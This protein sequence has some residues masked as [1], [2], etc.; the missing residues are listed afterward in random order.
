MDQQGSE[1]VPNIVMRL[2]TVAAT[3]GCVALLALIFFGRDL[4]R[5][6]FDLAR[7]QTFKIIFLSI[8]LEALPFLLVGVLVS[9]LLQAFVSDK[10]IQK[11]TPRNPFAGVLFGSLLGIVL[12]LCE[13]GMIP[14]VRRLI[15]KGLPAYIGIIYIVAGP[16]INPIVFGATFAAFRTNRELAYSRFYLAFLVSVALGLILYKFM[17]RN[18][19][20]SGPEMHG[21]HGHD[22]HNHNP[23]GGVLKRLS[24]IPAHSA[25]EFF[26]MGK[27]LIL[28]SFI[29]A[30]L[31]T[32]VARASFAAVADHELLSHLFM[33]GFAYALSLCSTS[34]AFVAASFNNMFPPAAL[35]SFLV[36]GPML[37]LKNTLMMLAVFRKRFVLKFS[38]LIALLVLF[39][40]ILFDHLGLV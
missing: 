8:I 24:D 26:D 14:I 4:S 6:T 22:H 28:G 36:F 29:T 19:L 39:G 5:W 17:K 1:T 3:L 34:D 18:P 31:Q 7:L 38:I 20:K 25:E 37:D 35:L 33:M 27:Y 16:I 40:S 23:E 11:L 13:C 10:L 32:F 2:G 9:A 12:P 15:R 30:L 21:H